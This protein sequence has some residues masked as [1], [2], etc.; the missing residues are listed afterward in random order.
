MLSI[1]WSLAESAMMGLLFL[2]TGSVNFA[3]LE[4]FDV[5][6]SYPSLRKLF[7]QG[8]QVGRLNDY[9]G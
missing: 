3:P 6:E 5:N 4:V 7:G 2:P 9:S 1:P 8:E